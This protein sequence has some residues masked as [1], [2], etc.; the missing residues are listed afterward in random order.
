V[1][2]EFKQR[3]GKKGGKSGVRREI[4]ANYHVRGSG[5]SKCTDTKLN[6]IVDIG[7]N[8]LISVRELMAEKAKDN[9]DKMPHACD[10]SFARSL[11]PPVLCAASRRWR[12]KFCE[13]FLPHQAGVKLNAVAVMK[14]NT[15]S[16]HMLLDTR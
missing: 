7:K 12:D 1:S 3:A 6:V 10:G 5:T 9:N 16:C 4:E 8:H 13:R 11:P 14:I 15:G 2:D